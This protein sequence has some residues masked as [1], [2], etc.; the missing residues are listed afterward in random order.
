MSIERWIFDNT[1]ALKLEGKKNVM[2]VKYEEFT[3]APEQT[4]KSITDFLKLGYEAELLESTDSIYSQTR[5]KGN[6][7]IRQEQVG[8]PV[9]PNDGGWRK[10]FDD[11]EVDKIIK[12]VDGLAKKLG[13]SREELFMASPETYET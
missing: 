10:V 4:L 12:K 11:E 1:E 2:L 9:R 5:Q 3:H 7:K 13:Y 6:M 8:M